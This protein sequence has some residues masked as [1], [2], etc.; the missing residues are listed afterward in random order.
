MAKV[1]SDVK[2]APQA[3]AGYMM[4]LLLGQLQSEEVLPENKI[5]NRKHFDLHAHCDA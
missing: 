3:N 2:C 4:L 1:Q 5:Y